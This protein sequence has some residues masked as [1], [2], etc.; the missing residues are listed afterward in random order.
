MCSPTCKYRWSCL[1]QYGI[2][3]MYDSYVLIGVIKL[4]SKITELFSFMALYV[5]PNILFQ[6]LAEINAV[7]FMLASLIGRK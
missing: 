3:F 4:I 5:S 1:Y 6:S 2:D 7:Y